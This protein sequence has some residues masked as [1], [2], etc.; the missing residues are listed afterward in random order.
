MRPFSALEVSQQSNGVCRDLAHL[1]IALVRSLSVPARYVAGYLCGLVPQDMHAWLEVF[2][3]GVG[4]YLIQARTRLEAVGWWLPTAVMRL[5]WPLLTSSGRAMLL[6]SSSLNQLSSA[7]GLIDS[8]ERLILTS[9][10]PR[11][12]R[13][14]L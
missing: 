9:W 10:P 4:M 8:S 5:M 2:S 1:V 6:P 11:G 13:Y 3:A 7:C 14:S 12:L